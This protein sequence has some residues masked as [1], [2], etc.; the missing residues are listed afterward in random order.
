MENLYGSRELSGRERE[1]VVLVASGLKNREIGERIGVTAEVV[2]NYLRV[3][4]DKLGM[5]NRLELAL[6]YVSRDAESVPTA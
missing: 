4:Y 6:W 3:V 5:S 1:I 2:K